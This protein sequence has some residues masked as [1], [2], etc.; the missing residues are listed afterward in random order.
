MNDKI[1]QFLV[2][3]ATVGVIIFNW[4]AGTGYVNN[5]TPAEISAR[6]PSHLT[7]AGYAFAIWGLIYLGVFAFS[8]Y[9]ALPQNVERFRSLRDVYILSCAANCAWIFFW[10]REQITV[11]F[12]IILLLLAS[13]AVI[14]VRL[15]TT[16]N[17]AE[18]W[19]AKV[20]FSIY[21][22]WVTAATILNATLALVYLNVELPEKTTAY[23]AAS[24]ILIAS[25]L[26]VF[27]RVKL[28]NYFYPL[29]VAWALIAIAFK[30][31]GQP[32]IITAAAFGV[33]IC[34][35]AALSFVMNMPSGLRMKDEG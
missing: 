34:S 15:R 19:L 21:F 3:A 17:A 24:L 23:V 16:E 11:C 12:G 25:I 29:A 14:N 4:L 2:F 13:L 31:V 5:V 33:I 7:P 35:L 30:Q 32:L 10:H 27:V 20:P 1:K 18:Y 9:Q 26:A 28:T 6:Y 8:V 22:G